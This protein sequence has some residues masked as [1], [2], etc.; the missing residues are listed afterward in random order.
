[1]MRSMSQVYLLI[2]NLVCVD[3]LGS[4][5]CSKFR[6]FDGNYYTPWPDAGR[7]TQMAHLSNDRES[8]S[9]QPL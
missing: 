6:K 7:S 3:H 2:S 4:L 5:T 8:D 1:M 9:V